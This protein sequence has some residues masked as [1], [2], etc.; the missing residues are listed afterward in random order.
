MTIS[1]K[2]SSKPATRQSVRQSTTRSTAGPGFDFEDRVAA[3]L[4]LKALTGAPLPGIGGNAVKLQ[5]QVEA[6]G[7][8]IDDILLTSVLSE[9]ERQQLAI[10]CKSNAQVTSSALPAEFVT[11]CWRQWTKPDPNPMRHGA[12]R[13]A[14]VTRGCNNAF[15]A[16]WSEL[17]KAA[18]GNDTALALNRMRANAK[19]RAVFDSVWNPARDVDVA[20][21]DT[22]VVAMIDSMVVVPLDFHIAESDNEREAVAQARGLLADGTLAGG[23]ELWEQL[24]AAARDTRLDPGTLDIRDVWQRLRTRFALK[25]HPEYG[26]S[27]QRLRARTRDYRATIET[28]LPSGATLDRT[29][30]I[31]ELMAAMDAD[32]VCV[33]FGEAGVGKSALVK[34]MLDERLSGAEQVWFSPDTL[35]LA[36]AE[37][38]RADN[39]LVQPLGDVL[40]ATSRSNNVLVIDAA[41]RIGS[42]CVPKTKALINSL[43]FEQDHCSKPAWR[44]L[45]VTQSEA[46]IGGSVRQLCT[47]TA[48]SN[49]E[50]QQLPVATV[51]QILRATDGLQWLTSHDDAVSALTNLRT[52]AWVIQSAPEFK[53]GESE[54]SLTVIADRLWRLW[55]DQ[56]LSIHGLLIRLAE[57]EANFEHSFPVSEFDGRDATLLESLPSA[58][59]LRT[60]DA[61]NRIHFQHDL[62]A[63]WARYQRLKEI[64]EDTSRWAA[65]AGNP[66]WH[67]A[68]RMLGQLLL[69]RQIGDRTAWDVALEATEK[70]R[71]LMPLA[72]D[73]L[74]D[75][76]FLD[77]HAEALLDAR[78]E[79]LLENNGARLLRLV[80]RFEHVATVPGVSAEM[81]SRFSDLGLYL[82]AQFRMPVIGRWPAMARFLAKHR[83][84]IAKLTSPVIA[85]LC[86]RWL[87]SIPLILPDG[88]ATPYRREFA[89]IAL[90][91]AREMQLIRAKGIWAVGDGEVGIYRAAFSGAPDLPVEVSE[92]ALEMARRRPIRA[93]IVEQAAAYYAEQANAHEERL[94]ND[95]E[96][97]RRHD[98]LRSSAM[99]IGLSSEGLPPWPLGPQG[100]VDDRF[101]EAVLRSAEFQELMRARPEVAGEVL[102]ACVIEDHPVRDYSSHRDMEHDLGVAF[103]NEGYPTA[104]W[105]SP[106]YAFLQ[107]NAD[108]ALD[109]LLQ[110]VDFSTELWVQAVRRRNGCE[111]SALTLRF[112]DGAHRD[113][114]GN[115]WVFNWSND[116]STFIGQLH[117]TLAALE[118]WLCNLIDEGED[119]AARLDEILCNTSSVAVLGVLVNVG[120]HKP[121]SFKGPLLPLLA[122]IEMY[123][124]DSQRVD[125]NALRFDSMAWVRRGEAAFDMA[126]AWVFSPY[127][128]QK[129]RTLV[130]E[131]VTSDNELG[132][133]IVTASSQ[134]EAPTTG[135]EAL[136]LK[137]MVAELDY[138]NFETVIDPETAKPAVQF[139]YPTDVATD[140]AT[141]EQ[142]HLR[143]RQA[144]YFP[145]QCRR[146][147]NS[148]YALNAREASEV[149]SLMTALYG[150]EDVELEPD[151]KRV[152]LVAAAV[153]LLLRAKEWLSDQAGVAQHARAILERVWTELADYST[154]LERRFPMAPSH[155]EF[156]AYY[157]VEEWIEDPSADADE[158]LLRVL[159]SGD[160]IAAQIVVGSAYR[161]RLTL[162]SRWWRLLFIALLWSGLSMLAPQY[163]DEE[164][165]GQR[166]QRWRRWLLTRSLSIGN[167]TPSMIYPLGIARR[168]DRLEFRRLQRRYAQD[169]HHLNPE[170]KRPLSGGLDTDFLGLV[171]SWLLRGQ[172]DAPIPADEQDTHRR[173]VL[174]SW[175]QQTWCLTRSGDDE[176]D[177]NDPMRHFGYATLEELARL[178]LES[179]A[180]AAPS[181]W[182]PVFGLG[183]RGHYAINY[184]IAS[185]FALVTETTDAK[186]FANRWRSM[187]EFL[188]FN[189]DWS[190]IGLWFHAEQIQRHVLGFGATDMLQRSK[191]HDSIILGLRE[192]YEAWA[193]QRL[194]GEEDNLAGFC[195]FLSAEVGKPL[196]MQG[197]RWLTEAMKSNHRV[198]NW[199]RDQTSSAFVT[200]LDVLVSQHSED[201]IRNEE[202]RQALLTLAAHAVSRQLTAAQALQD[203]IRG[204]KR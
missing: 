70:Q 110:L 3:W 112:S 149:A 100:R 77:L 120:K 60:N 118:R 150:A 19:Y 43:T 125:E 29:T 10:S 81:L 139:S 68:L 175:A 32:S 92:W 72:D 159:T 64:A 157:A 95:P 164:Y 2:K 21:S 151:M 4:L 109:F 144:L 67:G 161:N 174:A 22:E 136:E 15:M 24:V 135:K 13:L 106:F 45:I 41:E 104:P 153:V 201:L 167:A 46:W 133:F 82:E 142:N 115:R 162:R 75:A 103:E 155:L 119:V 127:R 48:P 89:E 202:A 35:E 137:I 180:A 200:F 105:K 87:T 187:A 198:G 181:L 128:Q 34:S 25:D 193:K 66:F 23:Q 179:P 107:I 170:P 169:G 176:R 53:V 121:K 129:L 143:A 190:R 7:W 101:R 12:D 123:L 138:R 186:V 27:W 30:T 177:D 166:W 80:S 184:F 199:R 90:S 126:K 39:G 148:S 183:P 141:F 47:T 73:V 108:V 8:D 16:T 40:N 196:R 204:L 185:W 84:R 42:G 91:S 122:S 50:I 83:D 17:K 154:S 197:V 1:K 203:R 76:L 113:Y 188:I 69:R 140:I 54:M 88:T 194:V 44:V 26:G 62:A 172:S 134:W 98:R 93:D 49:L 55:T 114:L 52:L 79:M 99:P 78:A 111:P 156:V 31:N 74:L 51:S 146:V 117:S 96:Y 168:V 85:S 192:L 33:I 145:E 28:A 171:F 189:D 147:L 58:C 36:L 94:K 182:R 195:G 165:A 9:D 191:D 163:G 178:I 132:E 6:L 158:R 173:L 57:R 160:D 38:T 56:K 59:P 18:G 20:V 11:R 102:L 37:A 61:T 130:S 65:Y 14:L 152:P 86:Q 97:R 124:W 5:M 71:D 131:I 116:N 63:D